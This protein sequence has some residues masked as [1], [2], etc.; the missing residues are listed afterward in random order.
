MSFKIKKP[1]IWVPS[2]GAVRRHCLRHIAEVFR[3]SEASLSLD[4]RFGHELSADP[5]SNFKRNQFDVLDDDI[6]DVADTRQLEEMA[7][8]RLVIRTVGE[9][10]EHMVRCSRINPEEVCYVLHL[11]PTE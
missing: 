6:R 3:V 9:Y 8:G 4:A 2:E 11:S 10:C 1:S 7:Q 5:R